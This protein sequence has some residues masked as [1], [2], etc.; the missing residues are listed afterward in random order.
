MNYNVLNLFYILDK[1]WVWEFQF[2]SEQDTIISSYKTE[3]IQVEFE[4]FLHLWQI[5][6]PVPYEKYGINEEI[7]KKKLKFN[8]IPHG[9]F[10]SISHHTLLNH[11]M[12]SPFHL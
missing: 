9:R 10:A 1:L 5:Q 8:M 3:A 12:K 4:R 2:H 11:I 6:R 7:W